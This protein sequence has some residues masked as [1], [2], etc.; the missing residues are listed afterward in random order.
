[1]LLTYYIFTFIII[2]TMK[3]RK[4]NFS[5]NGRILMPVYLVLMYVCYLHMA[6]NI[7]IKYI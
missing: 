1:M 2:K 4:S 5:L 3:I 6:D 7:L